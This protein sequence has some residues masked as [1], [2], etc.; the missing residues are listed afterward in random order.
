MKPKQHC[1][2]GKKYMLV[3]R[4]GM[5]GPELFWADAIKDFR[6]CD[7][8]DVS[9]GKALLLVAKDDSVVRINRNGTKWYN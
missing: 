4:I 8:T 6:S 7:L 3:G 2:D 9:D 1:K 5:F